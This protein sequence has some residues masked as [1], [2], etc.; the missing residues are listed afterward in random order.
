M[1]RLWRV[2]VIAS[3]DAEEAIIELLSSTLGVSVTAYTDFE[4]GRTTVSAFV[5][6]R[7]AF[8]RGKCR[9]EQGLDKTQE[10]GLTKTRLKVSCAKIRREDWAESW[11]RHFKPLEIGRKL[12]IKASWH[13]RE[14]WAGQS[15]IILDPGLSFGTGHHPTT[16]FCLKEIARFANE[17]KSHPKAPTSNPGFLD[18]GTGSGILAIAAA[19]LGLTPVDAFDF[20]SEALKVARQN[21]RRNRVAGKIRFYRQDARKMRAQ[22]RY[23]IIC[24]NLSTDV[25]KQAMAPLAAAL[26]PGGLLVLAGILKKEFTSIQTVAREAGLRL[27]RKKNEKEWSSGAFVKFS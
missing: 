24:A 4:T 20:D 1:K 9:I 5:T 10:C 14:A 27:L 2:S 15:V 6:G 13:R 11:K 19:K 22:R 26:R 25:L 21:A 3:P 12:L 23:S 7:Q 17:G 18:A 16:A 8:D